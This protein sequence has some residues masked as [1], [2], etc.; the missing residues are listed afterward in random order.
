M[1][2]D[3]PGKGSKH[4]AL[5]LMQIKMIGCVNA[6]L[7]TNISWI[8]SN[9][10]IRTNVV[11]DHM[12]L[13]HIPACR[14]NASSYWCTMQQEGGVRLCGH[15]SNSKL[16]PCCLIWCS[17]C[18]LFCFLCSLLYSVDSWKFP[19]LCVLESQHQTIKA[20]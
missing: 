7:K 14:I 10:I 8:S 13:I 18:R 5:P 11:N 16:S 20:L 15:P 2:E 4:I 17:C 9:S 3:D 12:S 6:E 19:N 1:P